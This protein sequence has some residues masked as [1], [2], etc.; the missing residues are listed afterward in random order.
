MTV[1]AARGFADS[2]QRLGLVVAFEDSVLLAE[3]IATREP[4]SVADTAADP[5]FPALVEPANLVGVSCSLAGKV[6][7]RT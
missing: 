6:R 4:L 1:R 5:R 7:R 3:M 2:E